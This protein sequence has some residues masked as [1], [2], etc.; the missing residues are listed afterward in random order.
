MV[1]GE[2][3]RRRRS[4]A[5]ARSR[6]PPARSRATR[7]GSR[8]SACRR[9]ATAG[10]ARSTCSSTSSSRASSRASSAT[11]RTS[12]TSRSTANDP[13][14]GPLPPGARRAG[15]RRPARAGARRGGGG[16]VHSRPRRPRTRSGGGDGLYEFA[17]YGPPGEVP[18]LPDLEAAA[19]DG[20]VEISSTE[21]PD[22]WADRWR[23]FHVP[24][25][26]GGGRIVVRPSWETSRPAPTPAPPD[27]KPEEVAGIDV[28]ID[29]G[30]A[31][32]TG[33]HATTKLCLELLLELADA[34]EAAGPLA[35]LGTGSGVLGDLRRKARLGARRG[36]RQRARV[37]RGSRRERGRQWRRA[38][39]RAPQPARAAA[40]DRADR[41]REPDRAAARGGRR[42]LRR[43]AGD[44]GLL[45]PAVDRDRGGGRR[46]RR[47]RPRR[48][49]RSAP[50]ATGRRCWLAPN[51]GIPPGNANRLRICRL[52]P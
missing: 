25:A 15:A 13:A 27:A 16:R 5:S 8:A 46:A 17:I 2:P 18:E 33:A 45:G 6:S 38:R 29:P 48:S 34:G 11:S 22:D 50:K 41:G 7:T 19:G 52:S 23:D 39:A 9:F 40:A 37:D 28:V 20:L 51:S 21:I 36:G 35:D 32:G 49:S 44:P 47:R 12:C 10:E 3:E 30:Q 1:G 43:P 14:R 42:A 4:T 26:I 24:V 31:F